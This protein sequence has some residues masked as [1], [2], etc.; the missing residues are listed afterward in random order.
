M[1]GYTVVVAM[2]AYFLLFSGFFITRDRI[3]SYW[4]WFHYLSLVKY[5]YQAVLQNEFGGGASRCF[6]CGVQMFDGSPIGSLPE[7]VKLRVLGAISSV[8]GT[9]IT[10]ETCVAT[11]TDV[12]A[13]QAVMDMGKW[14]CLLVTVAWSFFFRFLFYI[15]LLVGNTIKMLS[16][17]LRCLPVCSL[18]VSES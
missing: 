15:V 8:L 14:T 10:A 1:L 18:F 13:Q 5:P 12:L 7:A 11:G 6:S 4:T 2:L 3:P 16:V 9:N 17:L